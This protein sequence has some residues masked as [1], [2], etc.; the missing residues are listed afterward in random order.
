VIQLDINDKLWTIS[1]DSH[2]QKYACF[3]KHSDLQLKFP[4]IL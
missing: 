4:A 3:Q 2:G 1:C